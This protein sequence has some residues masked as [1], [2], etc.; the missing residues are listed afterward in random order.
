MFQKRRTTYFLFIA[1][2]LGVFLSACKNKTQLQE[3][4]TDL[5]EVILNDSSSIDLTDASS[6]DLS[7][8]TDIFDNENYDPERDSLETILDS[9]K[10]TYES[11]SAL[12]KKTKNKDS[13]IL[14]QY[15][16]ID[17]TISNPKD[18]FTNDIKKIQ[19]DEIKALRYNLKQL[20]DKDSILASSYVKKRGQIDSRVWAR[21][22]KTDQRLYLYIDGEVVD[23]FK[24]ST[25]STRHET[26]PFDMQPS[27][28]IFQK[29]TSKTYPGG[30]Y[31]GLGNMPYAIFIKGG[32]AIHGTTR[33]NI[34]R[35]GKKASHGCV[36]MHPENAKILNELV[37]K[38]GL[39]NFW[40]T[41]EEG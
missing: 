37:R 25:G 15:T 24:V 28:P 9:L 34:P 29:Y 33:G 6:V 10:T 39:E 36:R 26:P 3:D 12:I 16:F 32:Y 11:D 14:D 35:L 21:V 22:S 13:I 7:D 31:D 38:A 19:K 2:T 30:N 41:I 27:G 1:L 5:K 23:T 40:I 18:T 8:T 17:T 4:Y 20:H